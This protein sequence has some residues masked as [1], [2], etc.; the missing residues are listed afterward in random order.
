VFEGE[1]IDLGVQEGLVNKAGAWYSYKEQ[2]IGQ[3]KDNARQFLKDNPAI[4]E[5]LD[6]LLRQKLLATP[7]VVD[8]SKSK[9]KSKDKAEKVEA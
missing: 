5:E 3:G 4:F 6:T 7:E 9:G 2:R 1:L 8:K